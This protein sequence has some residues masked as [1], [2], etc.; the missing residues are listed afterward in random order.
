MDEKTPHEEG[1]TADQLAA[2]RA[3]VAATRALA[4]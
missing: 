4:S 1:T 3:L 2:P